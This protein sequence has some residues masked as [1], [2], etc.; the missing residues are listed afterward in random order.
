MARRYIT[1]LRTYHAVDELWKHRLDEEDV[2]EVSWDDR[3]FFRDIV[4]GRELMIGRTFGGRLLT[5]VVEPTQHDGVWDV[6][7]G[8][9]S[10]KGERTAWQKARPKL[11]ARKK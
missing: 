4:D 7:T 9:D 1:E 6:V 5:I 8:W 2:L 3:T 11:A 10:D